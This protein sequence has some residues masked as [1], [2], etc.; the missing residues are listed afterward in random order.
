MA[1]VWWKGNGAEALADWIVT[2]TMERVLRATERAAPRCSVVEMNS[3]EE[4][5][6]GN[7]G[8]REREREIF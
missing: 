8:R 4:A 7:D 2:N 5:L 6:T 1:G 3:H